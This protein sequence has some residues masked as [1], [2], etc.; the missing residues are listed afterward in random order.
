MREAVF[1]MR[2]AEKIAQFRQ[3]TSD[4]GE[5]DYGDQSSNSLQVRSSLIET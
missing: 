3:R 2:S 1:D 4:P 5:G